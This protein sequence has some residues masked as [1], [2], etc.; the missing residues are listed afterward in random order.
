MLTQ[1]IRNQ[2]NLN[3]EIYTELEIYNTLHCAL[4]I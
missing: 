2:E 4:S 3:G 1:I